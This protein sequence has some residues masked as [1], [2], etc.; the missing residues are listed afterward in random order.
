MKKSVSAVALTRQTA[1]EDPTIW[2]D[3]RRGVYSVTL[4]SPEIIVNYASPFWLETVRDRSN[5]FCRRLAC[6]VVGEAHLLKSGESL[7]K[8]IP[9][10]VVSKNSFRTLLSSLC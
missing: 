7:R 2:R 10:R 3:I 5:A 4:S 9:A 1:R 6:I 8:N